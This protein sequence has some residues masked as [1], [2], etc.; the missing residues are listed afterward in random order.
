ARRRHSMKKKRKSVRRRKTRK[1]QRK[2]K[3]SLGRSFKAHGF[4]KQP[5]R[6][7]P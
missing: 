1:N 4:L 7:R 2:R 3:N 5:P 6:F